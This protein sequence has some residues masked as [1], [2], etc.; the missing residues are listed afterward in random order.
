[1]S[2][3][4]CIALEQRKAA[5]L[6]DL[7]VHVL[8]RVDLFAEVIR[9]SR[10]RNFAV[11][12]LA[13]LFRIA[14]DAERPELDLAYPGGPGLRSIDRNG[15]DTR[16]DIFEE[17]DEVVACHAGVEL[18]T[19]DAESGESFAPVPVAQLAHARLSVH[20]FVTEERELR[21]R[22]VDQQI[23]HQA[24]RTI[25]DALARRMSGLVEGHR[26]QCLSQRREKSGNV[27]A[28]FG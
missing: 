26:A 12:R 18:E 9:N 25:H 14:A 2:L 16:I 1:M 6:R 23:P 3:S 4:P 24:V 20:H 28:P 19:L 5:A 10:S 7:H 17:F 11:Q 8:D 13:T 22:I 27:H 21:V 15:R